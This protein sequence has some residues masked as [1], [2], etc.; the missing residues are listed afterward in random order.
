MFKL[1]KIIFG[2]AFSITGFILMF[3]SSFLGGFIMVL[4]GLLIVPSISERVKQ[5]VTFWNKRGV[6]IASVIFLFILGFT[7]CVKNTDYEAIEDEKREDL[8]VDYI[9]NNKEDKSIEN[10]KILTETGE[11]FN[12]NNYS[13][14]YPDDYLISEKDTIKEIT[15]YFF[16]PKIDFEKAYELNYLMSKN[17]S[18]ID[19][20][21]LRF[22]LDENDSLIAEQ[23]IIQFLDGKIDTIENDKVFNVKDLLNIKL[24]QSKEYEIELEKVAKAEKAEYEKRVKEF[25]ENCLSAWDGSHQELKD[26]VK[27]NMNDPS[28]FEHVETKFILKKD[29]VVLMMS[30]RGKNA[31]GG[32]VINSISGKVKLDDCSLIE[33]IN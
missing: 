12:N 15:T 14:M 28:S 21:T 24:V 30:F 10:L 17:G 22:D 29:Y 16:Q 2:I 6:R 3:Q 11:L 9:R 8:I 4:S 5:K 25:G 1:I 19:A 13:L 32:V 33:I 26:Y 23:T 18:K 27:R 31:F 20:Y 7:L